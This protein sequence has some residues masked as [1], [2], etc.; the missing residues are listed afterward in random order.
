MPPGSSEQLRRTLVAEL[1]ERG[2]LA[3]ERIAKAFGQVPREVFVPEVAETAG[4]SAVYRD[5]AIVTKRDERGRPLSSSSQP[6]LMAQMLEMLA[7]A[8]GERVLEVGT[9]TGY[10]TALL[11]HVVG[12]RGRVTTVDVDPELTRRARQRLAA[13]HATAAVVTAD[14]RAGTRRGA[15]FDRIIATAATPSVPRTWLEQLRDG[16]RLVLPL[17]LDPDSQAIQLIPAFERRG[18]RLVSVGMTWG[19]FMPLHDGDGGWRSPV[20]ALQASRPGAPPGRSLA[21]V[22]GAGLGGLSDRRASTLLA[23]VLAPAGRAWASG[24]TSLGATRLPLLL[25]YL[26]LEIPP[27]RRMSVTTPGRLGVGLVDRRSGSLGVLSVENPWREGSARR[28]SRRRWR[29]DAHGG[30]AGAKALAGLVADWQDLSRRRRTHLQITADGAE[31]SLRLRFRWT[32][33]G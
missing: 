28:S 26:L 29:L 20:P 11:A 27:P 13:A 22:T 23:S 9:G 14:G 10:N 33:P 6:S 8:P 19:G 1:R 17:R 2:A 15:P 16:G 30:A 32:Q 24:S 18:D 12:P 25:V 31:D 21:A 5:E 4:L 7:A 3:S